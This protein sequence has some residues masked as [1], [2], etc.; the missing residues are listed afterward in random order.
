MSEEFLRLAEFFEHSKMSY[1]HVKIG[2]AELLLSRAPHAEDAEILPK[3]H[4]KLDA[5]RTPSSGTPADQPSDT[6]PTEAQE[7]P[8]PAAGLPDGQAICASSVG[9]FYRRPNP[10]AEPYVDIGSSVA[11]GTTV[12]L[13]EAMKV[14]TAVSSTVNGTIS[15]V[16]VEDQTFVEFGQPLFT[17]DAGRSQEA[18][19]G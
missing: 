14:F 8:T 15:E 19:R 3:I 17:V 4:T 18:G 12:G 6:H 13:I 11:E 10:E 7:G 9:I 2:E 1:M 5:Q 16:L